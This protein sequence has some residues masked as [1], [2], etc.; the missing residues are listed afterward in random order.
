[1]PEI[2]EQLEI[3]CLQLD[4]LGYLITELGPLFANLDKAKSTCNAAFALY[5]SNTRDTWNL[6]LQSLDNGSIIS[7]L[8]FCEFSNRLE[9]SLQAE[10]FDCAYLESLLLTVDAPSLANDPVCTTILERIRKKAFN[11]SID[12]R[13]FR[14]YNSI[15][16]CGNLLNLAK[17]LV[18]FEKRNSRFLIQVLS[19]SVMVD[20]CHL[21]KMSLI[22]SDFIKDPSSNVNVIE[23]FNVELESVLSHL[24][25]KAFSIET[26]RSIGTSLLRI[27]Q[28][29]FALKSNG[30]SSASIAGLF[31][32]LS[33]YMR[34]LLCD[35]SV[36]L[37]SEQKLTVEKFIHHLDLIK[38]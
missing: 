32:I 33:N 3:K 34:S 13:D 29:Q 10:A 37:L 25:M 11:S 2:F 1:M 20:D 5:D 31:G 9:H 38:F 15:D 27:R 36:T 8:D 22:I 26:V 28:L 17:R 23:A 19:N 18:I 7:V 21:D 6:I 24:H 14:V 12:N 30:Q 4:T 35:H 16:A